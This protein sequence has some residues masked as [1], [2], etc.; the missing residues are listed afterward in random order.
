MALNDSI[1]NFHAQIFHNDSSCFNG[2]AQLLN[3][4]QNELLPICDSYKFEIQFCSDEDGGANVIASLLNVF[5]IQRSLNVEITIKSSCSG[6]QMQLPVESISSWLNQN[7]TLKHDNDMSLFDW[8]N[9]ND[10]DKTTTTKIGIFWVWRFF[11]PLG[12]FVPNFQLPVY[13][14]FLYQSTK[15]CAKIMFFKDWEVF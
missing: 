11:E 1:V 10:N 6:L 2:R 7:M 9:D 4:I 5:P 14:T 15:F 13:Q 12:W 3:H 8:D